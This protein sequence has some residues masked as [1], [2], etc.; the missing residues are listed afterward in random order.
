MLQHRGNTLQAHTGVDG[1][2]RQRLHGTVSLTVELHEDDVPDLDVTVAV[3]F[4]AS[5]RAA[6]DVI[7]VV[8]EDFGARA[9]RTGVA[10]LPEVIRSKRRAFVVADADDTLARNAYFIGPDVECFVIGLVDGDPQLLFRQ[11]EPVFTGQQFPC[12]FDGILL[13]IIAKAEVA[14]HFKEGVVTRGVTD[15]FQIVV[16]TTRTHATLRGGRARVITFVEAKEDIL[17][18]VHPGVGKQQGWI[19][20]RYQGAA[21]NYLMSLTMEKVEKRLTDLSG[22]LAH[23]YPEIKLHVILQVAS[24]LA[25]LALPA[26]N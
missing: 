21:G 18:L 5:R 6:P 8:K 4:R 2:L 16:F 23:N 14:Q 3:F 10:H 19:V 12:V 26:P 11:G 1:R 15:V 9:A 22:A 20:V 25:A 24:V 7:A 17:E 13:E